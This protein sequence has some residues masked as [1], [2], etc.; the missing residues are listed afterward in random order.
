MEIDDLKRV[1]EAAG[2]SE[3]A[4]EYASGLL[5]KVNRL[6]STKAYEPLLEQF[7]A[8]REAGDFRGRVLEVNFADAFVSRHLNLRY[9]V[10]QGAKGDVDFCYVVNG[11]QIFIEMKLLGQDQ[12]TKN[13]INQQLDAIGLSSTIV[14]DDTRD[15]GRIQLDLLQKAATT[16][17]NAKPEEKWIN[18]VAVDVSELQLG[19]ADICDCLLAAGGNTCAARWC[20]EPELRPN[21]VGVFERLEKLSQLQE[22]WVSG[23]HKVPADAPHPRDYIHGAMFL[24]RKPQETAALSYS[25][26][27]AIV[28]NP[29]LVTEQV[30]KPIAHTFARVITPA[31]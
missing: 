25:L 21:V 10:K 18:L 8:A 15:I 20:E 17:F 23:L 24:F 19:M 13:A 6:E 31:K 2:G 5:E 12:A 30:A 22:E 7:R 16:K 26:S 27:S 4:L 29:A 9:G 3:N 1:I 14:T 11:Y 28:W